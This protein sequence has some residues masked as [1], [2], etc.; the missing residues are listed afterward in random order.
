MSPRLPPV[1]S[2]PERRPPGWTPMLND[3]LREWRADRLLPAPEHTPSPPADED[4]HP[5]GRTV[6]VR[7]GSIRLLR[8]ESPATRS[9]PCFV[10]VLEPCPASATVLAVP[11]GRFPVPATPG[12]WRTDGKARALRVLCCWN[13]RHIPRA[14]IER[15]WPSGALRRADRAAAERLVRADAS[16]AASSGFSER[17]GPPIRHPCDPRLIYLDEERAWGD[18]LGAPAAPAPP[19]HVHN[20]VL[21]YPTPAASPHAQAAESPAPYRLRTPPRTRP[22]DADD[23]PPEPDTGAKP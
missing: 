19:M 20:R 10:A 22:R 16:A 3:W 12:E 15:G 1:R 7:A 21:V 13:A 11:F 17:T 14:T 5:A 23:T 4:R 6:P 2:R 9:R 8:P 18:G